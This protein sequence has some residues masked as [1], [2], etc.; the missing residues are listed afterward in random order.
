MKVRKEYLNAWNSRERAVK[1]T[2]VQKRGRPY[3][4]FGQ[5]FIG[6][7]VWRLATRQ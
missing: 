7:T 1:S 6:A 3:K 4:G 2:S 5:A